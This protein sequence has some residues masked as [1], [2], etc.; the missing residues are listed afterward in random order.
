M[1]TQRA[2]LDHLQQTRAPR[3]GG[4]LVMQPGET[5][6]QALE[7]AARKGR[8]GGVLLMPAAMDE[9]AWEEACIRDM[10]EQAARAEEWAQKFSEAHK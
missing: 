7:R 9:A 10:R 3:S 4:V 8:T 6:E 5:E 2:R 1:K